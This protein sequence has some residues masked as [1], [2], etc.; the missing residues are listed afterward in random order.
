MN[1][2]NNK[3]E[4]MVINVDEVSFCIDC[5]PNKTYEFTV[6]LILN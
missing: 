5:N 1:H 2:V 3:K 4:I 6:Y